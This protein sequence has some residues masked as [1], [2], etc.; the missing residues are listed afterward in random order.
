MVTIGDDGL[1]Y[2]FAGL[3]IRE[4][5]YYQLLAH[6]MGKRWGLAGILPDLISTI[7]Y[8]TVGIEKTLPLFQSVKKF[9]TK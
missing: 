5:T 1:N 8:A 9:F 7:K 3:L 2:G 4:H 6:S